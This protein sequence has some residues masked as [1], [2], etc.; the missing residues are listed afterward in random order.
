MADK[1]TDKKS[2]KIRKIFHCKECDYTTSDKKDYSKH[3]LTAKHKKLTRTDKKIRKNPE[4]ND[5]EYEHICECGK[6]YKHRQSL[7]KHQVKCK[8]VNEEKEKVEE[9]VEEE[10]NDENDPSY[11]KLFMEAMK[12]MQKQQQQM[13]KQQQQMD[14]MMPLIGNNN[15][16][17]NNNNFNLQFFLNDTCKDALNITDFLNSLQVQ[18]KDLEYITDNGHINGITN[19]F[20]TALAN[21]EETKR[22]MH[23]TDLKREVL[24]I[25]E[26]DEWKRDEDKE[27][28]KSAVTKVVDKN[29][30]NQ[31]EWM[32]NHPEILTSGS[33][34]SNRYVKMM[35]ASL[36]RGD[37]AEQN[38]IIKNI[39]KE[40]IIDK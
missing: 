32:D 12:T 10:P 7:H 31:M 21:M 15:N 33:R 11:K 36:G 1:M 29:I 20:H 34:D 17:T 26:N 23:C 2:G 35:D 6:T 5:T 24:Y 18:L 30:E 37:E 16:T 39:L 28:I 8:Y 4:K 13:D 14:K 27:Q 3:L 25:K 40:V 19:I 22:P 9:K 38:K